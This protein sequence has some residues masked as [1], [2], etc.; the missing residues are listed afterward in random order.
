MLGKDHKEIRKLHVLRSRLHPPCTKG[1][2][3]QL[4]Q[5]SVQPN[6]AQVFLFSSVT[7]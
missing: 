2:V 1:A 5:I 4:N 6:W 3:L 7:S